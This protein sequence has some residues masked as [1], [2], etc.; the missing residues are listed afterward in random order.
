MKGILWKVQSRPVATRRA[1]APKHWLDV[2]ADATFFRDN[3]FGS[4]TA[5]LG[6]GTAEGNQLDRVQ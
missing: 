5:P 6:P 3:T 4:G 1:A 2:P